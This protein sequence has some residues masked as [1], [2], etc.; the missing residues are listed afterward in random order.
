MGYRHTDAHN[1]RI[2]DAHKGKENSEETKRKMG[3]AN[4]KPYPAF[5]HRDTGEIIPAGVNLSRMCQ[6]R[7][8]DQRNMHRVK[9]GKQSHHKGWMLLVDD[10]GF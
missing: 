6:G 5:I 7:G 9:S 3:V 1:R 8:L 10:R 4:A 2:G